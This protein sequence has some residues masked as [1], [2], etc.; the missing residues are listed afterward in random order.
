MRLILDELG[1]N[2]LDVHSDT[3]ARRSDAYYPGPT[4]VQP[5]G[6]TI[7]IIE[8]GV[9]SC[10]ILGEL[11]SSRPDASSRCWINLMHTILSQLIQPDEAT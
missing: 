7:P 2:S 6:C 5:S 8:Q 11:I 1:Y 3:R 4:V 10:A 9:L